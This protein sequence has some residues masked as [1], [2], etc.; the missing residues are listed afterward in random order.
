M[1]PVKK[2]QKQ[3]PNEVETIT[4]ATISSKAVVRLLNHNLA[5][6]QT[7]IDEYILENNLRISQRHE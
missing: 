7:A 2:G 5:V 6:W 1:V 3:Y 4:G